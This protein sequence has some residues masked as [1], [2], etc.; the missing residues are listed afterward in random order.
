MPYCHLTPAS[1]LIKWLTK[2]TSDGDRKL[3]DLAAFFLRRCLQLLSTM[4]PVG[5]MTPFA[6][7]LLVP[8][9][10]LFH[11]LCQCFQVWLLLFM[12]FSP[13]KTPHYLA[14]DLRDCPTSSWSA[15]QF[16]VSRN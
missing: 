4:V 9:L 10:L 15:V 1:R 16:P 6:L 14:C 5:I 8:I 11:F 13:Y 2:D 3:A 7:L 12:V